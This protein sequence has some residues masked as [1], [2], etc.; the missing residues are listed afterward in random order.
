MGHV[1]T[2]HIGIKKEV[3]NSAQVRC[4]LHSLRPSVQPP[5]DERRL[6][7]AHMNQNPEK[8]LGI[9]ENDIMMIKRTD[10]STELQHWC[11]GYPSGALDMHVV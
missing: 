5:P 11:M 7:L 8:G 9:M 3:Y 10:R 6:A 4:M 1:W 2:A